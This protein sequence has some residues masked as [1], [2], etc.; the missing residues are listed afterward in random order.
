[1][2][3]REIKNEEK[4][5]AD[6]LFAIAFEQPLPE[7]AEPD[8]GEHCWAAFTDEGK[9]MSDFII[10]DALMNFDGSAVKAGLIGAV[11]TLPQYRRRGGIR[12][13]FEKALPD[14]YEKG[15]IFSCL[16]PF[17]SAYYRK[18]GYESCARRL[19]AKVDL[20]LL[21]PEST[22]GSI[23]LAED[24]SVRK[25][26]REL[27]GLWEH[28]FNTM[29]IHAE[30]DYGWTE[31]LRPAESLEF[32]YIYSDSTGKAKAYTV[33]RMENQP[34]GR[35]L[36]C[37][38]FC[39]ADAGGFDGLMNLFKSLS[40]DHRYVK[41]L[42]PADDA[43]MYLLPEWAMGAVSWAPAEAEMV[44]VINVPE[45]LKK[46]R[47]RGS[48]RV[49]LKIND[50]QIPENNKTFLTEFSDGSAVGAEE[51]ELSPDAEMDISAFSALITGSCG[52]DCAAGSFRSLRIYNK[53]APLYSVFYKKRIMINEYF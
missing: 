49:I 27:D 13:C 16:Y 24:G 23:R 5:R 32:C 10:S 22:E 19:S 37:S 51:T 34:D 17:S 40:A 36:V 45:V 14:M 46:A 38:R 31:K 25:D 26:I 28:S 52:I 3:V 12:A 35:N 29:I 33:F 9:M 18:F 20:G 21:R 39:F 47:Y 30:E 2:K 48:G 50:A 1:M 42:L 7:E 15:Y 4:R 41:F 43:L 8:E 11:A 6:E 53:K 44:R